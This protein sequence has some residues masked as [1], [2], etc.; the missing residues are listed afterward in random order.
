MKLTIVWIGLAASAAW[1][2][3]RMPAWL[4]DYPGATPLTRSSE[5]L[6]ESSYE[7]AANP[8]DVIGHYRKLFE[9]AGL[10]WQPNLDGVGTAIRGAAAECD[11][12]IRIREQPTGTSVRVS[13]AA[14]MPAPVMQVA[15]VQAAPVIPSRPR[16]AEQ[17]REDSR[18]HLEGME[19]YD[20]PY[21]PPP[22]APA[23]KLVWPAWLVGVDGAPLA[24][25]KGVD[26]FR[27]NYLK[28]AYL[29]SADRNGAVAFYAEVLSA[30]GYRVYSR[31]PASW[32]RDRKASVEGDFYPG[33]N[34]GPRIVIHVDVT[35]D[36]QGMRVD[37]RMTAHQ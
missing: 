13:C 19:K 8:G 30:N 18:K 36:E 26:Q 14:R 29:T 12:L 37:V 16:S 31:T 1:P 21:R 27:L 10:A 33:A 24:V 20:Q 32:P 3:S 17:W 28:S 25:E 9:G 23:P 22:R 4:A 6:V 7:V 11:L 2:Q 15:P 35:S 34:P 5:M